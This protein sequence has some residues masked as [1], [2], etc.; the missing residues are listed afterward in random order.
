MYTCFLQSGADGLCTQMEILFLV[1]SIPCICVSSGFFL[2]FP[3]CQRDCSSLSLGQGHASGQ[4]QGLAQHVPEA[5]FAGPGKAAITHPCP[6][7]LLAS[8]LLSDI[9]PFFPSLEVMWPQEVS[10]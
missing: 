1:G 7:G 6:D 8:C 4:R 3:H 10:P 9:L 2:E 5:S